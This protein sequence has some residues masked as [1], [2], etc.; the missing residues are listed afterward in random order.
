MHIPY[1]VRARTCVCAR[2]CV[3]ACVRVRV[4]PCVCVCVRACV[5]AI[6][7]ACVRVCV[8]PPTAPRNFWNSP[9]HYHH[10]GRPTNLLGQML[11]RN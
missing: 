8:C 11:Y 1:S 7:R 2:A 3:R 10:P 9:A 6:V 4:S 5:C